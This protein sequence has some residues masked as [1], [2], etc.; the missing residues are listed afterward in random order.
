MQG[1]NKLFRV[2][3]SPIILALIIVGNMYHAVRNFLLFLKYGGEFITHSNNERPSIEAI[4]SQLKEQKINKEQ[5]KQQIMDAY[6]A[7]YSN[8]NIDT[9]LTK[10]QY[11]EKYF[12]QQSKP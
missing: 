9:C 8:G 1:K 3:V 2:I 11:F 5:Q 10:E 6:T 12:V 7:G 4:Y